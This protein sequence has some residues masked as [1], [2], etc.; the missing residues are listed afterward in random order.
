MEDAFVRKDIKKSKNGG[1]D[2]IIFDAE[3]FDLSGHDILR[4]TDN[5]TN[6]YPYEYLEN[7][8]SLSDIL[9]PYGAVV[10]LYQTKQN[11]GHWV[12]ILDKG[13]KHLEFYDPYGL[14]PDQELDINNEYHLRLHGGVKTPHLTAFINSEGWKVEYNAEKLQKFLKDVNTCGRYCALRVRFRDSSIQKFN[15]LLKN[16]KYYDPDFWVSSLTLLT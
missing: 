16:N 9:Q 15:A 5:K 2:K 4:I 13:N 8:S 11:F 7:V 12:A 14:K 10:L 6:I 1:I 3:K